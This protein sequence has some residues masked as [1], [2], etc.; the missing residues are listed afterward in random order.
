MQPDFAVYLRQIGDVAFLAGLVLMAVLSW[1]AGQHVRP[2]EQVPMQ[3]GLTG[4]PV[5]RTGRRLALMFSPA[6]A[7][8]SGLVLTALAHSGGEHVEAGALHLA[9]VR[10]GM[11][12]AF[13][14]AH[15]AHLAMALR[16]LDR[17]R[18]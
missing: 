13:V 3:W 10:T 4:K 1:A 15:M 6:L 18:R 9:M 7:G 8:L 5:W 11:A 16:T 17:E 14:L 2:H 12:V